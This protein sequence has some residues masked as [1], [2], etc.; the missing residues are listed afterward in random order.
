MYDRPGSAR[1]TTARAPPMDST[2]AS[3][4]PLPAPGRRWVALLAV[5]GAVALA[6]IWPLWWSHSNGDVTAV[7]GAGFDGPSRPLVER[8]VPE[9]I[10]FPGLGH[11]GQQFYAVARHPFDP[12]AAR[13][14]LDSPAYRYRRILYPALAGALAP[15][16]GRPL[17]WT[18]IGVSLAG[19]ALG[20]LAVALLPGAPRWLPLVVGITPGVGV[21]CALSLCDALATGLALAAVAASQHR[22]WPLA[23]GLLTAAVLTRETLLLVALGLACAQGLPR[24][25]RLATVAVPAVVAGLWAVWSTN[26]LGTSF[27]D[28]AGQ[29]ALPLVGW[30]QS[31]SNPRGLVVGLG[32]TVVL[33]LAALH[34]H[35][36]GRASLD[37]AVVLGLHTLLMICL[38]TDVT[39]SWLNTTRVA[40]PVFP[41]AVWMIVRT[42]GAAAPTEPAA[43]PRSLAAHA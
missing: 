11:D 33:G 39:T 20:A 40:A 13:D 14:L 10:R 42:D 7:L 23:V 43:A 27:S 15:D 3:P 34:A 24:A 9:A 22:R 1:L 17:V 38:A 25:W 16:G 30:L 35:R 29:V 21:A 28:G 4:P 12:A 31:D 5:L 6:G 18:L 26:E 19:V 37:L 32:T 41:L 8:E 2:M 36:R